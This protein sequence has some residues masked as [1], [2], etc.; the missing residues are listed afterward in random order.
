[1]EAGRVHLGSEQDVVI[2]RLVGEID[3]GNADLVEREITGSL[4]NVPRALVVDLTETSYLDSAG[5]RLIF[6]LAERL[7]RRGQEL[8]LVVP[9]GATIERVLV[10]TIVGEVA[11]FD[12]TVADAL[13]RSSDTG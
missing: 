3:L 10:L 7:S 11:S 13:A 2:A 9:D 5:I 4:S 6:G 12:R 1:M 8:R